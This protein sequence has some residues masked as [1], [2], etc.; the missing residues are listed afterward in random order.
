M[1]TYPL[2]TLFLIAFKDGISEDKKNNYVQTK[3]EE[4]KKKM[5]GAVASFDTLKLD[6]KILAMVA[7]IPPKEIDSW[8]NN[9]VVS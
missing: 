2:Y 8:Q 3:S 7:L 4:R 9:E 6:S 5:K 1:D